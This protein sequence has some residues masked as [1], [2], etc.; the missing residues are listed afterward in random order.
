MSGIAPGPGYIRSILTRL[1]AAGGYIGT[2]TAASG[3]LTGTYPG[4]TVDAGK[5][6]L[7]KLA[8]L[9]TLRLIG[10]S[11]AGTGVPEAVPVTA[12]SL[13]LIAGTISCQ[14][15]QAHPGFGAGFVATVPTTVISRRVVAVVN[16]GAAAGIPA[17]VAMEVETGIATGSYV[18]VAIAL[19]PATDILIRQQTLFYDV[20]GGR[21]YRFL[22]SGGVGTTETSARYGW[23][24]S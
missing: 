9:A 3:D 20:P 7:A 17:F 8:N 14:M 2:G 4:P 1:L 22:N 18:E 16:I 12:A 19:Q 13:A 21:R 11:T 10:R 24:E 6:T 15:A 5:I 23:T